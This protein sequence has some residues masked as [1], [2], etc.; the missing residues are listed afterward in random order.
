MTNRIK[1]ILVIAAVGA[2]GG[3]LF[4]SGLK[5]PAE[6][7][8]SGVPQNVSTPTPSSDSEPTIPAIETE[9]EDLASAA[10]EK[11]EPSAVSPSTGSGNTGVE[12]LPQES[13]EEVKR[14]PQEF[15]VRIY[16]FDRAEPANLT[17]RVG[18]TVTFINEDKN[19]RWPGADPHPTHSSLPLFDALGGIST[20]QSYSHTFKIPGAYLWHDHIPDDPPTVGTITVIQ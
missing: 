3:F 7:P 13:K 10:P 20:G 19:L 15:I 6:S 2:I 14:E 4:F 9:R 18:D 16:S 1:I 8:G 17:I 11:I 5:R 12:P